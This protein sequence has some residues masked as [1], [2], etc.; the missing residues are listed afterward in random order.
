MTAVGYTGGDPAKVNRVGDTMT[1]PLVLPGDPLLDL[2]AATKFYVDTHSGGGGGGGTPSG[3]VVS[4]TGYGQ[5]VAPGVA[6]TYSR[7]DHT[8]G[9]PGL[10]TTGVTAAAGN[11]LHTGVYDAN[12]AAASALSSA[13]AAD[14]PLGSTTPSA[15]SITAVGAVGS[16]GSSS[17]QDHTHAGPGFGSVT[18]QTSFGASSADGVA[19]TVARS[20]HSHGTP[21]AQTIPSAGGTVVTETAFGQASTA[22]AA[23]TFS[24]SDHTHGTP[25][26]PTIPSASSTVAAE[27][28]YGVSSNAGAATTY[29]KGDHTHGSPSLTAIAPTTSAVGDAAAI[30]TGTAPA[31]EDHKHGRE[32]FGNVT[33]QTS[34]GAASGNGAASTPSR[35]DHTHGTPS[36][37]SPTFTGTLTGPRLILPPQ[38]LTDAA[39]IATD[40]SLA[41]H[42]RVTLGSNRTLGNPTN[43]VDGQR[44]IW[45]IIQDATGSRTI[46]LDT[47]FA[48]G[49]DISAV[50]LTT[51]ANKRDFIGAVYNS[52]A[53]KWYVI[54]LSRGY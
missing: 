37:A 27:T 26:A 14:V 52:T 36:L 6:V 7:G 12:G 45:E 39:T 5:A 51:G 28:S 29:S 23:A 17:H 22:G 34:F 24:R 10:G 9:S 18:A 49:T 38:T 48:L 50:T 2:Q 19:A 43:P 35:S 21:V 31:R 32:A 8:H 3:T 47:K 16:S 4:E 20:D 54:A 33:A 46:T 42:F 15:V 40:A 1:G 53:D 13:L 44:V 25:T 30:G 41:N 11:H